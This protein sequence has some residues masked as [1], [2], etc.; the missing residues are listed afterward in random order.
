MANLDVK[1][2]GLNGVNVDKN[3]FELAEG[4]LTQAQNAFSDTNAGKASLR[5]RE[6]LVAF[7]TTSTAG[8]VFG[9]IGVPL[10]NILS[11]AP[12]LYIGKG[13]VS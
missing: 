1:N 3:P 9:G 10:V 7:T 13:P 6:G 12:F 5:K 8:I 4:E 11:G 2:L